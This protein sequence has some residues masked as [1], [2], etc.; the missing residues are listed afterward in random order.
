[1]GTWSQQYPKVSAIAPSPGPE[2]VGAARHWP[3]GRAGPAT[4]QAQKKRGQTME[5]HENESAPDRAHRHRQQAKAREQEL[6]TQ[7]E[8]LQQEGRP[9]LRDQGA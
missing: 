1:M 3:L 2:S 4:E 6:G 7:A 9:R 8:E 5:H